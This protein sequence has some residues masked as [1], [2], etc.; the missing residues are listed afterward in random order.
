MCSTRPLFSIIVPIYGVEKYLSKCLNS[1]I[2][3]SFDDFEAILINDGYKDNCPQIC[4]EYALKDHRLRVIVKEN[5]GI[6]SAR[7]AGAVVAS[8]RYVVCIDGDDWIG[9]DYLKRFANII[10]M[11]NPDM[12]VCGRTDAM[13]DKYVERNPKYRIGIYNRNEIEKEI[14]P[15]L[16]QTPQATYF[17]K[18]LWAKTFRLESFRHQ[19]QI[20]SDKILNM[21]EDSACMIP[22]LYRAQTLYVADWCDYYYRINPLSMT[23]NRKP[24]RTDGPKI[25]YEH[26]CDQVDINQFDFKEQLYRMITHELFSVVKS[27]FNKKQ[28]FWKTRKEIIHLINQQPYKKCIENC[29]FNGS[30]LAFSME[31]ALKLHLLFPI[32]CYN[33]LY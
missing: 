14:F 28:S 1:I 13:L 17:P 29:R 32:Y 31:Y 18:T 16:L 5:E 24:L 23:K 6:V 12:I 22:M 30:I 33:K 7:Q 11:Y 10:S 15:S 4:N 9:K 8:G 25:I 3:Q 19:Q 27:Q 26:I 21:G 2:G 20:L